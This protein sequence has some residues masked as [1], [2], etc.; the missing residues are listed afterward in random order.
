MAAK[1]ARTPDAGFPVVGADT[2]PAVDWLFEWSARLFDDRFKKVPDGAMEATPEIVKILRAV[3]PAGATSAQRAAGWTLLTNAMI[4][5]VHLLTRCPRTVSLTAVVETRV[6]YGARGAE[7]L[8][9]LRAREP[10]FGSAAWPVPRSRLEDRLLSEDGFRNHPL[11]DLPRDLSTLPDPWVPFPGEAEP[12]KT[13]RSPSQP[14]AAE[15]RIVASGWKDVLR[16]LAP[17]FG[18]RILSERDARRRLAVSGIRLSGRPVLLRQSDLDKLAGSI[19]KS[20]A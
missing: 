11:H 17:S 7:V 6:A 4:G 19:G 10:T 14:P 3:I 1:K 16:Q 5:Y 2:H 18:G 9:R 12:T 13:T 20:A 15:N 8:R